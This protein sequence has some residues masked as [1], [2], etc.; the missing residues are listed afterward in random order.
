MG[1]KESDVLRR[2]VT[3]YDQD[4]SRAI[5]SI[6]VP[7]PSPSNSNPKSDGTNGR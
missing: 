4:L 3:L 1:H 2:Y 7:A 6:K 5:N